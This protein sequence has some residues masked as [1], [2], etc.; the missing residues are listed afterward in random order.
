MMELCTWVFHM[1]NSIVRYDGTIHVNFFISWLCYVYM[2][3]IHRHVVLLHV[4]HVMISCEII[5]SNLGIID[6]IYQRRI[7]TIWEKGRIRK[8]NWN[9]DS[10]FLVLRNYKLYFWINWYWKKNKQNHVKKCSKYRYKIVILNLVKNGY[11]F[12]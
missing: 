5:Y 3:Q 1:T 10:C 7:K 8:K 9:N 4:P 2:F 12:I 11:D 6:N